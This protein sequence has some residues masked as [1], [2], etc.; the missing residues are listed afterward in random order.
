MTQHDIDDPPGGTYRSLSVTEFALLTRLSELLARNG[1]EPW[2]VT[3]NWSD[4]GGDFQ[5]QRISFQADLAA[6]EY[7]GAAGDAL[8]R[9]R[10]GYAAMLGQ[11]G[12]A[13]D[14]ADSDLTGR[15]EVVADLP[16]ELYRRVRDALRHAPPRR[17]RT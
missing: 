13:P 2:E 12:I 16:D 3:V 10:A 8:T 5:A 15:Y 17:G 6:P 14:P 7:G 11:M 9:K 4:D 1:L